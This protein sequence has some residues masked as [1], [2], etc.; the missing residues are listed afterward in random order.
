VV[1]GQWG[2]GVSIWDIGGS[3]GGSPANPILISTVVTATNSRAPGVSAHNMW[4]FNDPDTGEKRWLFV[5][6]EGPSNLFTTSSGDIHVVDLAD[7]A[8]PRQV[9]I[10]SLNDIQAGTHNFWVDEKS[11]VLYAAYY[12]GG[13][14]AIDVLGDLGS[15]TAA[16]KTPS[17]LCDLRLMGREMGRALASADKYVWGVQ[18]VGNRLYATD[19]LHGLWKLDVSAFQR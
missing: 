19:M 10:Y 7:L 2:A 1:S 15:C 9:A 8:N 16:Q 3:R 18:Q 13:V 6:Q 14:R 12:N 5:G 17:G 4:W 11:G